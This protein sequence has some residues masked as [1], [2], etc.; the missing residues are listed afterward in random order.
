M[1]LVSSDLETISRQYTN[2][3]GFDLVMDLQVVNSQTDL[4]NAS[5]LI[6]RREVLQACGVLS[7]YLVVKQICST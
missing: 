7:T 6:D 2:G 4:N 3:V 5:C 1:C